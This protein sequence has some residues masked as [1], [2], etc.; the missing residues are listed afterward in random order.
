MFNNIGR[1]IKALAKVICWAGILSS[2]LIGFS[3]VSSINDEVAGFISLVSIIGFGSFGSWVGS[4]AFYGFGE[5][6]ENSAII[7]GKSA[8]KKNGISKE[9]IETP[10]AGSKQ[11]SGEKIFGELL[12]K[13][14][15]T[16]NEYDLLIK[17]ERKN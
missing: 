8:H 3:A 5:L 17:K 4:L 16:Q 13:G 2:V 10:R 14:V 7:A 12:Q 1:K 6:I 11:D 9:S 15:I